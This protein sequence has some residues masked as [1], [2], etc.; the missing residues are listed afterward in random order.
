MQTVVTGLN[1]PEGL[2]LDEN[3]RRRAP[4]RFVVTLLN[5]QAGYGAPDPARSLD[6][7]AAATDQV[8]HGAVP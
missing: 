2:V 8:L 4:L 5:H 7:Q 6:G 1:Y 3:A